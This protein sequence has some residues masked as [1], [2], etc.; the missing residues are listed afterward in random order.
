VYSNDVPLSEAE[1]ASFLSASTTPFVAP[2][3][4]FPNAAG[5]D[6]S[7]QVNTAG[8][9]VFQFNN[10]VPVAPTAVTSVPAT[11]TGSGI[12]VSWTAPA[13]MDVTGYDVYRAVESGTGAFTFSLLA[14]G[15]NVSASPFTD[16]TATAAGTYEYEVT[17]HGGSDGPLPASAAS[18]PLTIAGALLGSVQNP[19]SRVNAAPAGVTF[20]SGDTY[21]FASSTAA[22]PVYSSQ[23]SQTNAV[24]LHT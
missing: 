15:T 3:G 20:V 22:A 14:A 10:D 16:A 4:T 8:P 2:P 19:T 1:F 21:Q 18:A 24:L 23:E 6:L 5:D 9:S 17:V 13:N 7:I 12:K 11:P